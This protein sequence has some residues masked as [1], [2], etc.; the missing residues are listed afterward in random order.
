MPSS[1]T[2]AAEP[3]IAI[4]PL[5]TAD[6]P[7]ADAI[8]MA[9]FGGRE[10]RQSDLGRYLAIQPDGWFLATYGGVAAG[11]V[12][13]MDYGPFAYIGLMA[14][15]PPLQRRGIA[16]ALMQHLLAW[17]DGRGTPMALLDA[18]E[19]GRPLYAELGFTEEDDACVYR[20]EQAASPA[21]AA[22]GQVSELWAEHLPAVVAFDRPIFGADRGT[23]LRALVADLPGRCFVAH[24]EAGEV[25]GYCCAQKRRIGPWVACGPAEAEALLQPVLGLPFDAAPQVIVPGLNCAAAP[26]LERYGFQRAHAIRHMRR[27]GAQHPTRRDCLYGQTSFGAG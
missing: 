15:D 12:G 27:G 21:A 9:A 13:A 6:V 19:F 22:R 5:V 11:T 1:Q 26:L 18:T 25:T 2:I 4:R 24:D 3:V 7:A 10:S 14:V 16:R 23:L 20:R 8:L 17:L